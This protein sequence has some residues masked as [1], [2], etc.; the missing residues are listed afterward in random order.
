MFKQNFKRCELK[1]IV[2]TEKF[3]KILTKIECNM[4]RDQFFQTVVQS[5][6]YDTPDYLL[7]RR[8]LEKPNYKEKLR[9]RC[10]GRAKKDSTV[11]LEIKKKYDGIVYKRRASFT[12]EK[13]KEFLKD[14]S[15]TLSQIEKE[16]KYFAQVYKNI[17]PKMLI[18][19]DR[20]AYASDIGDLRITF[21]TNIRY[22][23]EDFD[24]SLPTVGIPLTENG[25]V[26]MEVKTAF[27][28]PAW[29]CKLL[30]ENKIY[31]STYSKYG[32]AYKK[33]YLK[34]KEIKKCFSIPF[35]HKTA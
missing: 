21:D 22:R 14:S 11:F 28:F 29:L 7:I 3:E 1:Y 5:I 23:K 9:L 34:E 15:T 13:A 32:E 6:Y 12:Q 17:Q 31:K 2:P 18:I 24:L 27:G 30:S 33:E 20:L 4:Q 35:L 10:Y 25:A 16:I 26:I 8:S 19:Y